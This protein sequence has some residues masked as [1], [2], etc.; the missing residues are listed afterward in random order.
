MSRL[1]FSVNFHEISGF[2]Q[3]YVAVICVFF[4]LVSGIFAQNLP[5]GQCVTGYNANNDYFPDKVT[6]M[7][8]QM[9]FYI[10]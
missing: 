7:P 10:V 3:C 9:L 6:G 1:T 4:F 2:I 8:R 5:M